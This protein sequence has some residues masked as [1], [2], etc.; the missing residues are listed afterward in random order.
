MRL[1]FVP[2]SPPSSPGPT[3][4]RPTPRPR[5]PRRPRSLSTGRLPRVRGRRRH[6]ETLSPSPG[7]KQRR[8]SCSSLSQLRAAGRLAGLLRWPPRR[9]QHPAAG[10]ASANRCTGLVVLNV[11]LLDVDVDRAAV[12]LT[13]RAARL[14]RN[15]ELPAVSKRP[16]QRY[17][18]NPCL[19][20]GRTSRTRAG[21][22]RRRLS[23][24][25]GP[26]GLHGGSVE[27]R[28]DARPP[29]KSY[30]SRPYAP[31]SKI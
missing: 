31:K 19:A 12:V 6:R 21:G 14:C 1:A 16:H 26:I 10:A 11:Q 15:C 7:P 17:P 4:P 30:F 24:P 13:R 27:W 9:S 8:R 18:L 28:E 23:P 29:G 22:C 2:D 20:G 25:Q 5:A 3:G